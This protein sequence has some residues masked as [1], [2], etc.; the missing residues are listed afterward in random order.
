MCGA[1]ALAGVQKAAVAQCAARSMARASFGRFAT[2]SLLVFCLAIASAAPPPLPPTLPFDTSRGADPR[3][4]ARQLVVNAIINHQLEDAEALWQDELRVIAEHGLSPGGFACDIWYNGALIAANSR[5]YRL[6]VQRAQTASDYARLEQPSVSQQS[7]LFLMMGHWTMSVGEQEGSS[8]TVF[9]GLRHMLLAVMIMPSNSDHWAALAQ[10]FVSVG[11]ES[12]GLRSSIT[13]MRLGTDAEGWEKIGYALQRIGRVDLA[14]RCMTRAYNLQQPNP[15]V[16]TVVELARLLNIVADWRNYDRLVEEVARATD[17]QLRDGQQTALQ[18]YDA[19]MFPLSNALRLRIAAGYAKQ[20]HSNAKAAAGSLSFLP[21]IPPVHPAALVVA[22]MSSDFLEASAVGRALRPGFIA[23]GAAARV[24]IIVIALDNPRSTRSNL[25]FMA[26][27]GGEVQSLQLA[28]MS[29][30]EAAQAINSHGVHVLNNCNGYTGAPRQE[31][32]ALNPAP[33]Q[34]LLQAYPGTLG[35]DYIGYNIADAV[36][37]Q[38]QRHCFLSLHSQLTAPSLSPSLSPSL[39]HHLQVPPEF[40]QFYSEKIVLLPGTAFLGEFSSHSIG[41][42]EQRQLAL[43]S[44]GISND[45]FV[46]GNF[47]RAFK[48]DPSAFEAWMEV[49]ARVDEAVM[50]MFEWKDEPATIRNIRRAAGALSHRVHFAKLP[51]VDQ[52]FASKGLAH[53]FLDTPLY[54]AHGTATEVLSAGVP[55]VTFA[56]NPQS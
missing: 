28:G 19:L 12:D 24:K 14:T 4:S 44:I 5:N 1:V 40:V 39:Y 54:N 22:F 56:S 17:R 35:A 25:K 23:L 49:F 21:P 15:D 34:T 42:E 45:K 43:Q 33:I 52:R 2:V 16:K 47:N 50:L 51:P 6:A 31:I 18:P 8:E 27:L 37:V 46:L 36:Q 13:V 10:A 26:T 38:P 3:I 32:Y 20:F 53:V 55:V 29:N 48:L 41:S 7:T 11:A 9:S 30:R